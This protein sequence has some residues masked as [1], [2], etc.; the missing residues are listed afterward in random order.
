MKGRAFV[1]YAIVTAV[2]EQVGVAA[3][4]LWLLPRLGIQVPVWALLIVMLG[5]GVYSYAVTV[6]NKKALDKR[7]LS[8]PDIGSQGKVATLLSPTGYVRI[9]NEL[10]QASSTGPTIGAKEEIIVT[11]IEGMTLLVAPAHGSN[12]Q[13]SD[14]A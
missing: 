9:G 1:A 2:L 3:V 5:L 11:A 13:P 12:D 4:A 6:L 8:L 10:W 7:P 14:R